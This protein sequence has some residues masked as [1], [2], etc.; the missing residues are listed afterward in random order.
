MQDLLLLVMNQLL[1]DRIEFLRVKEMLSLY[2]W[3]TY[4]DA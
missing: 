1:M 3:V 2:G 4:L